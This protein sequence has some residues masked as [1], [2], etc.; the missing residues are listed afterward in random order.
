MVVSSRRIVTAS[1]ILWG[2][3]EW[4][5]CCSSV[6]SL[7]YCIHRGIVQLRHLIN[8]RAVHLHKVFYI[9]ISGELIMSRYVA[10]SITTDAGCWLHRNCIQT[11]HS[12]QHYSWNVIHQL[13]P[14]LLQICSQSVCPIL[15]TMLQCLYDIIYIIIINI[16]YRCLCAYSAAGKPGLRPSRMPQMFPPHMKCREYNYNNYMHRTSV[17]NVTWTNQMGTT[18]NKER[19]NK[20]II[21][22]VNSTRETQRC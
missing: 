2:V 13:F 20:G 14:I 16:P 19:C 18:N 5:D 10:K 9:I 1:A 17:Y 3:L 15:L 12:V 4:T 8:L 7:S 11:V 6:Y 22:Q 21:L